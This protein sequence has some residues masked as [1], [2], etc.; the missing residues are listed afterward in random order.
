LTTR[1]SRTRRRSIGAALALAGVA[2]ASAYGITATAVDLTP[3]DEQQ[4]QASNFLMG[5]GSVRFVRDSIDALS[6]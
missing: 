3:R 2:A 1:A 6:L 5:D 4:Q